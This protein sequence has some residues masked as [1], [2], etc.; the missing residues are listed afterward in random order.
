MGG[1]PTDLGGHSLLD[2]SRRHRERTPA[3]DVTLSAPRSVALA[4][5]GIC[6]VCLARASPEISTLDV[7]EGPQALRLLSERVHDRGREFG[8]ER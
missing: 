5:L 3:F 4:P 2:Q 6:I 1:A 8:H 7:I